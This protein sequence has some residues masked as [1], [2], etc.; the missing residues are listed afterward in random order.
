[1][2]VRKEEKA[3]KRLLVVLIKVLRD[4]N[5]CFFMGWQAE[6]IFLQN[7]M[8]SMMLIPSNPAMSSEIWTIISPLPV[9]LRFRYYTAMRVRFPICCGWVA[10]AK[11]LIMEHAHAASLS[12]LEET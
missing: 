7:L 2:R 8:P 5:T 10:F 12:G 3:K 1:M 6:G 4:L 11:H 9:P